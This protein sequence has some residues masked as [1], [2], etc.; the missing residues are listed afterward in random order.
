MDKLL[1]GLVLAGIILL[2][3]ALLVLVSFWNAGRHSALVGP[4]EVVRVVT[5]ALTRESTSLRLPDARMRGHDTGIQLQFNPTFSLQ[6][7][8]KERGLTA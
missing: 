7:G 5:Q 2:V 3:G 6:S 4:T 1:L 8:E